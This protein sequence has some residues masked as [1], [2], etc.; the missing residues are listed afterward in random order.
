MSDSDHTTPWKVVETRG[1]C[2]HHGYPCPH[3]SSSKTVKVY[4]R[5]W[6]RRNRTRL[7]VDLA[8]GREPNTDQHRHEALW[9]AW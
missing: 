5:K 8:A 7:R 9:D 2:H 1:D 3:L 6:I 4:R